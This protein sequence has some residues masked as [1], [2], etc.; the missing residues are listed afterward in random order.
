MDVQNTP[1]E[2]AR[3]PG[4]EQPHISGHTDQIDFA[5]AQFGGHRPVVFFA[6]LPSVIE[7]DCLDAMFSRPFKP[8]GVRHVADDDCDLGFG[9]ASVGD[10]PDQ[11][12]HVRPAA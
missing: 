5:G 6:R 4:R 12:Q 3:E 10:R 1:L 7:R 9:N 8:G 2:F 11:R